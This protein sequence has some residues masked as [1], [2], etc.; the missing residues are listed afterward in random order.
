M[1]MFPALLE[2]GTEVM[3][4]KVFEGDDIVLKDEAGNRYEAAQYQSHIVPLDATEAPKSEA[5]TDTEPV[6]EEGEETAPE[7]S[8]EDDKGGATEEPIG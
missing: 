6:E 4:G 5:E 2:D 7:P 1:E 8:E 3:V